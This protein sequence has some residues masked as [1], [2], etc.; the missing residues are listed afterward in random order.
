M[1]M[2]SIIVMVLLCMISHNNGHYC[3]GGGV[4]DGDSGHEGADGCYESNDDGDDNSAY[5][6][7]HGVQ[8]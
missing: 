1:M 3:D 4:G 2:I 8:H 5:M 7:R 6:H